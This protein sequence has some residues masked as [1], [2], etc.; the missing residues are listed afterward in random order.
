MFFVYILQSSKSG[1]FYVGH[2][3]HPELRLIDHNAG[4]VVATRNKGPWTIVW[5]EGHSTRSQACRREQE[6][7]SF[8][9][10]ERIR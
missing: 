6:I 9:S 1:R 4:K 2:S 5:I 10:A 3:S 8:K 7:K